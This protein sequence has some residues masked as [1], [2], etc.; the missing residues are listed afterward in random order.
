[1]K[2]IYLDYAATTPVKEEVVNA[3]LPFFES[4]EKHESLISKIKDDF[5]SILNASTG[6]IIFTSSGTFS[7]NTL[8]RSLAYYQRDHGKGNQIITSTIE[9]PA[10][11]KTLEKLE[12]EGFEV[13]YVPVDQSGVLEMDLFYKAFSQKTALVTIMMMNNEIGT[14]QPIEEIGAFLKEK[15]TLFHVDAVQ[16]LGSMKIDIDSLHLD[17]ASFSAHKI[18]A[19]KGCGALYVKNIE[20]LNFSHGSILEPSCEIY[21][22]IPYIIGFGKALSLSYEHFKESVSHRQVLKEKLV[23]GMLS[24]DMGIECNGLPLDESSHPGIMNFYIP[25]M[26]GDSLVINYDFNGIAIS[27]GSACSS[28][29]LSASHVL[30]A[31]GFDDQKAKRCI[32]ITVGDNTSMDDIAHVIAVTE[33]MLKGLK[34]VK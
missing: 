9:H 13:V 21:E 34:Y 12:V 15:E 20:L 11:Y 8:I 10:V 7:D 18:Y 16:S 23:K 26:D 19:P 25:Q 33:E 1:M 22:N 32:R 24:L 2:K 30:K 3:M 28:G 31:I 17:A 4:T 27:S 6:E 14:K 5:M 29:A